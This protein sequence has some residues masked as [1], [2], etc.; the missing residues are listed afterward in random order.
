MGN[1]KIILAYDG[2]NYHGFQEQRGTKFVTIQSVLEE[3]LARLTGREIRIIAASRTD[4]GVHARGQVVNFI[5]DDWPIPVERL[6]RALNGILPEDIVTLSAEEVPG[7]F[8][9]RFSA[10]AKTYCYTIYNSPVPSPFWRLYSL[11]VPHP[12]DIEAMREAGRYILGKHDFVVFRALGTPVQSTE[13]TLYTVAVNR[14]GLLVRLELR[15]DGFLYHMARMIAGTLL[16]VGMGKVLP[17]SMPDVLC[18]R[19]KR[20]AGPVLPAGGLCLERVE[21][22]P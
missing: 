1:I 13:R 6:V 18:G 4:A 20:L 8:H 11:H 21:Y 15:A 16:R 19:E 7:D 2:T 10:V 5:A 22:G 3:R 14:S 12:L 9:A 17:G